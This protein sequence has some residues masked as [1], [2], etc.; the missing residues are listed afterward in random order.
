MEIVSQ[1]K[2]KNRKFHRKAPPSESFSIK[3][4]AHRTPT[5]VLSCE[6]CKILRT[7]FFTEHLQWLRLKISGFQ[8]ATFLCLSVKFEFFRAPILQTTSGKLLISCTSCRI[9]TRRYSIKLF[10][11]WFSNILYKKEKL[12]FEWIHFF[13]IPE[14]YV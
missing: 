10:H 7:P 3:L 8:S 12:P 5:Q 4:Q 1:K 9:S 2:K 6:I 13:K 14:N 11:R